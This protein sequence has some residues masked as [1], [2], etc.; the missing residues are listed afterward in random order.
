MTSPSPPVRPLPQRTWQKP[1]ASPSDPATPAN[2]PSTAGNGNEQSQSDSKPFPPS[3][4]RS[5]LN[6]TS[7]TLFGIYS[8]GSTY[9]GD[10]SDRGRDSEFGT[11]SNT[12]WGTGAMTPMIPSTP[13]AWGNTSGARGFPS[14]EDKL[15]FTRSR[16]GTNAS[17][18]PAIGER[19]LMRRSPTSGSGR[20]QTMLATIVIGAIRTTLLFALG[21]AYGVLVRRLHDVPTIQLAPVTAENS[22]DGT[23]AYLICW[24]VAGVVLGNALP[25]MDVLW[26]ELTRGS[27]VGRREAD[28]AEK[29]KRAE[30][31]VSA[32]EGGAR[33]RTG[34]DSGL[35]AD[36]NPAVRSI[37]AFIGIAFAIVSHKLS[38]SFTTSS[39]AFKLIC[40]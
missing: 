7:S 32:G 25:W 18:S 40:T 17:T 13:N 9:D 39:C 38:L 2:E 30:R 1:S 11:G 22:W 26:E 33:P 23:W 24:S 8:P 28:A 35:G 12:P 27:G 19:P 3:R 6:L 20:P 37:G 31:S 34:G 10:T 16:T 36:W 5:I 14:H 21:M 15:G 4:T 29:K